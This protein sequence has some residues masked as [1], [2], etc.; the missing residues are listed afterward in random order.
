MAGGEIAQRATGLVLGIV[1]ARVLT[2]ADFGLFAMSLFFVEFLG[3]FGQCGLIEALI[4]NEGATDRDWSS[5]YWV[6]IGL[7]ALVGIVAWV[8]G[9]LAGSF[10][11]DDR[12]VA[13]VRV[14]GWGALIVSLGATQSAWLEKEMRFR[15]IA[16]VEWAGTVSGGIVGLAMALTGWG[17]WSLVA[18]VMVGGAIKALLLHLVGCP[19]RP[20]LSVQTSTLKWAARFGLW[21]QAHRIVNYLS[22]RLDDAII[23]RYLGPLEVGYYARAY[24]LMLYAAYDSPGVAGRVMF[25]ALS[26]IVGDLT[27]FRASYLRAVS[28]VATVTFPAML[29]LLAVAPEAILVVFG[30]QWLPAVP[31]VRVLSVVGLIQSV[32]TSTGWIYKAR[33]RTDTMLLWGVVMMI[34][35]CSSFLVG[36]RWGAVGVATAYCL[37]TILLIPLTLAIPFRLIHLPMLDLARSLGGV[38]GGA[39]LMAM[40]VTI[41]RWSLLVWEFGPLLVL[42]GSLTTGII[43]YAAWLWLT[44]NW[45]AQEARLVWSRFLGLRG[46]RAATN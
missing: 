46:N 6:G 17:V 10:Y 37:A 41:V 5:A 42:A 30:P 21:L 9:P 13:V 2:P 25:P 32:L 18:R 20:T 16:L 36:V 40:A 45:A 24:D 15:V 29:G 3:V 31:L 34:V 28:A 33:G 44:D 4:Q 26:T 23:G 11:H 19:W 7:G 8:V 27:R 14:A 39:I 22:R 38:F 43:S 1:L 12:V 35:F